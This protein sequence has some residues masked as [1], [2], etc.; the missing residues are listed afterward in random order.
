MINTINKHSVTNELSATNTIYCR[1]LQ[2]KSLFISI[3]K[4]NSYS[5][6]P[7]YSPT[8]TLFL[9]TS[10]FRR[11]FF[12][13]FRGA[14]PPSHS[15]HSKSSLFSHFLFHPLTITLLFSWSSH[16]HTFL[17]SIFFSD[18][19]FFFFFWASSLIYLP[20]KTH[21]FRHFFLQHPH[22]ILNRP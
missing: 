1:K 13:V 9:L 11:T 3:T 19:P 21:F 4:N 6:H 22:H 5:F 20:T 14:H 18:R 16:T 7:P 15:L 8:R 10:F 12:G 17:A 2:K